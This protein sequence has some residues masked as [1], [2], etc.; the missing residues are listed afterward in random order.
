MNS[1]PDLNVESRGDV[2]LATPAL[3]NDPQAPRRPA[4]YPFFLTARE[5]AIAPTCGNR[6]N[7][8]APSLTPHFISLLAGMMARGYGL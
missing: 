7:R 2:A 8:E 1:Y 6:G 4:S 3:S 5:T